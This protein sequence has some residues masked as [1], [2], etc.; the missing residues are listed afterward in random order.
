MKE[1]SWMR[2]Y[3][4]GVHKSIESIETYGRDEKSQKTLMVLFIGYEF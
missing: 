1:Q 3:N 4:C 2:K